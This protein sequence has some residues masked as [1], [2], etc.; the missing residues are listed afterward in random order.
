ML[1]NGS[2]HDVLGLMTCFEMGNMFI[3]ILS[4]EPVYKAPTNSKPGNEQDWNKT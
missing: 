3:A 2:S 4:I 1:L